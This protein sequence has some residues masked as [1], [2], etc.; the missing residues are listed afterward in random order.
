MITLPTGLNLI[1]LTLVLV[2]SSITILQT[3]RDPITNSPRWIPISIALIVGTL[4]LAVLLPTVAGYLSAGFWIVVAVIPSLGFHYANQLHNRGRYAQSRR[5]KRVLQWLHPLKDWPWQEAL[6]QAH[7]DLHAGEPDKAINA[8]QAALD[9]VEVTPEREVLIFVMSQDW[10]GLLAWW[11]TH[12]DPDR[13]EERPDVIRH[14]VRALGETGQLDEM[15]TAFLQYQPK[16][17]RV[18]LILNYAYLYLFAFGGQVE[19]TMK[20]LNSSLN[21][22]ISPDMHLIWLA[23]AHGAAHSLEMSRA[24]LRPLLR[25]TQDG[26]I[27]FQI[28]Q[29]LGHDPVI[30]TAALSPEKATQL[31]QLVQSWV[32]RQQMLAAWH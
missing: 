2:A 22:T 20:L 26:L 1:L 12:P 14:Y 19:E 9:V 11:E 16:M 29:R 23:T 6:Y 18:P 24:L 32:E 3:H 13:L 27:R 17:E 5:V 25:T 7:I 31:Q 15:V 4:L 30:A 8:L 28:E 10:Y 21:E